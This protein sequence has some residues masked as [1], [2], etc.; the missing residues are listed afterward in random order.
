[1]DA[2]AH[3]EDTGAFAALLSESSRRLIELGATRLYCLTT[4]QAWRRVLARHG[5]L[6]PNTPVL[7][8]RLQ[9]QTKWLTWFAADAEAIPEPAEWFVTL[10]D[11]DL[12]L[13]WHQD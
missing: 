10:G 3:P 6:F 12:D 8:L 5:F 7:G 4:P 2:L 13:A 1:V 9:S 11:C